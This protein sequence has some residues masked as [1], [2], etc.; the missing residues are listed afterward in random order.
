MKIE[1]LVTCK[2]RA[3]GTSTSKL[4]YHLQTKSLTSLNVQNPFADFARCDKSAN[5][6]DSAVAMSS[7]LVAMHYAKPTTRAQYIYYFS[8]GSIILPGFKF[9]ELH[10]LTLAAR[11]YALL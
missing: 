5:R 10:A 4:G 11:S 3:T 9:T 1:H 7:R 2:S 8:N 6:V